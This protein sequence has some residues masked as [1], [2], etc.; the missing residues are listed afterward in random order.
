MLSSNSSSSGN[1]ERKNCGDPRGLSQFVQDVILHANDSAPA[2]HRFGMNRDTDG[3]DL[4]RV[5]NPAERCAAPGK[6]R[7]ISPDQSEAQAPGHLQTTRVFLL[8]ASRL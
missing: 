8:Y 3:L 4:F 7:I 1:P 5:I 6:L 2:P